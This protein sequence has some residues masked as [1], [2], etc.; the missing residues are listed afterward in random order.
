ME[1]ITVKS[2]STI[3]CGWNKERKLIYMRT[4]DYEIAKKKKNWRN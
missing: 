4:F 1:N 2:H 3:L